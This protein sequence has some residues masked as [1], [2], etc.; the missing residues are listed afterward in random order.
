[1]SLLKSRTMTPGRARGLPGHG[2]KGKG[3]RT[4]KGRH[5]SFLNALQHGRY[6]LNLLKNMDIAGRKGDLELLKYI[7]ECVCHFRRPSP[8][9]S[10]RQHRS[11]RGRSGP[12]CASRRRHLK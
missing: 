5:R 10:N 1:M 4:V 9:V 11:W 2:A 12:G 6:S 7:R 8:A 3:P